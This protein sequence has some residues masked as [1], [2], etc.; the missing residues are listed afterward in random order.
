MALASQKGYN[1][2]KF[3]NK[4][5]FLK[6]GLVA[7]LLLLAACNLSETTLKSSQQE[8][9]GCEGSANAIRICI[10]A[11]SQAQWVDAY[12]LGQLQ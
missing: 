7:T 4:L 3:V 9:Y 1:M 11:A 8:V 2:N 5:E 10:T 6:V 12:T